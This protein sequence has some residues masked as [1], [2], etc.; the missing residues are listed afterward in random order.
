MSKLK[1]V[2]CLKTNNTTSQGDSYNSSHVYKIQE[3]V[4]R[5][6]TIDHEFCCLTNE[7]GLNCKTIPLEYNHLGWWNKL[8]LY[9]IPGPVFYLDL[10]TIILD[11]IDDILNELRGRKFSMYLEP[12]F[13]KYYNMEEIEH[14][15][16]VYDGVRW[17]SDPSARSVLTK[18]I[19]RV[20]SSF[21]YW[22]DS[23]SFLWN[24]FYNLRF[25]NILEYVNDD[26]DLTHGRAWPC[27]KSDQNAVS[28]ILN[29]YKNIFTPF[30]KKDI[31]LDSAYFNFP[32]GSFKKDI[33]PLTYKNV[34]ISEILS[35]FKI[36]RFHGAP[37]PYEQ[38]II[39]Y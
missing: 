16:E 24:D 34:D 32:I 22:E 2:V 26:G 37:R 5:Y 33:L 36:V 31:N 38:D 1:I 11:N 12:R 15:G 17:T 29:N 7:V 25:F 19:Q 30:A 28:Y 35:K 3:M 20:E 6:V 4:K 23:V 13:L 27:L 18:W 8:Q 14:P 9:K 21:M 39:T 10:D